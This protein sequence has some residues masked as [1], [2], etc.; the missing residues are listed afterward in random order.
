MTI[1]L[2]AAAVRA[3]P[4][5]AFVAVLNSGAAPHLALA[6]RMLGDAEDAREAV[7]EAWFRA[8]RHRGAVREPAAVRGWVRAIVARECLRLLRRRA[9]RR[10]LPFGEALPDLPDPTAAVDRVVADR[11][12]AERLRSV[13]DH[14]PPKQ[15]LAWGLRFDE[16]WSVAEIAQVMEVSTETVKTHLERALATVQRRLGADNVV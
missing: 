10:W 9:M 11:E 1:E 15:R 2:P 6:T 13:L 7:Q 16:G 8:W 4:D 14:L 3:S 5:E 12:A